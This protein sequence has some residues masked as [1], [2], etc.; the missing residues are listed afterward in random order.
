MLPNRL[1]IRRLCSHLNNRKH[2]AFAVF[3]TFIVTSVLYTGA[4]LY[5]P[6]FS[7]SLKSIVSFLSPGN[8]GKI[9][10]K[11][12]EIDKYLDVYYMDDINSE[13][14]KNSAVKGYVAGLG[15][16]YGEYY[17]KAEYEELNAD[18]TGNYKGIGVEVAID[19]DNLITVLAAYDGAPAA[20][21]G[22]KKGDKI[23]KVNDTEVNGDNYD[24]AINMMRGAGDY[25]KTDDMTLTIQRGEEA[26]ET[27]V[28]REKVISQ[29]VKSEMLQ[30]DIGYVNVSQF[31]EE[32]DE[33]FEMQINGLISKGAKSLIIDLRNNPGGML[34]T[35]VNMADYLL[36]K[37]EILRIV[38][39]DSDPVI[40]SS[41]DDCIN[42]P[43][44]VLING[45]SAS[46]SEVLAGAL[47][48]HD[49]AT[50]VGEKTYGKGVVQSIFD[51][52]DGDALKITTAKYYTPSGECIDKKGINPDV[53][54][55]MKLTKNLA[56]YEKD[57][58]TQLQK[59][60]E[61]LSK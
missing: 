40:Y 11:I 59:A 43:I 42:L 14:L 22:I 16:I 3:I 48:D 21:A 19:D 36:P 32:T 17:S 6:M 26:F 24:E 23:I 47:K 30:S 58:D 44:C 5:V 7:G 9:S 60:I 53:K 51:L 56:L 46:A 12:S 49:R 25:G 1:F 35:V 10:D 20:K 52:S 29:T 39:K 8:E 4:Y 50:L 57:E 41:D 31:A 37:G 38:G 33:D 54:A 28:T 34:T 13:K 27:K 61:E 18:L 45:S 15:D 55:E 2:I